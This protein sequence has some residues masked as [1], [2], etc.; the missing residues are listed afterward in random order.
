MGWK[1][2]RIIGIRTENMERL[3]SMRRKK[4]TLVGAQKRTYLIPVFQHVT[5][6]TQRFLE[7]L[8][9]AFLARL[10][11]RLWLSPIPP[12]LTTPRII[13]SG[14][15]SQCLLWQSSEVIMCATSATVVLRVDTAV[16]VWGPQ[17]I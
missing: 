17:W 6:K 12:P 5:H 4:K 1:R 7:N 9:A 16:I 14:F 13:L 10:Q 8:A 15:P 2:E 3:S 11:Q